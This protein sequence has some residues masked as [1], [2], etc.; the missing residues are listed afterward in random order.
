MVPRAAGCPPAARR[1]ARTTE[2]DGKWLQD[3]IVRR[4]L[5][6][7]RRAVRRVRSTRRAGLN[8]LRGRSP[9]VCGAR[10]RRR[11]REVPFA[12]A[13][14]RRAIVAPA[15]IALESGKARL[16]PAQHQTPHKPIRGIRARMRS[17]GR[18]VFLHRFVAS[19]PQ[20]RP[21][22]SRSFFFSAARSVVIMASTKSRDFFVPR[23][24]VVYNRA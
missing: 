4:L 13:E 8:G 14:G 15:R 17:E 7:G 5:L 22:D 10:R 21:T 16:A 24:P 2:R 12:L 9:G 11:R 1:P 18:A 6:P 20:K 3:R 23:I 19:L